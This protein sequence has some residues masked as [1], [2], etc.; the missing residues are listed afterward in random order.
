M[1]LQKLRMAFAQIRRQTEGALEEL[2][3]LELL[4]DPRNAMWRCDG[5]G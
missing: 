4:L 3:A 2:D 1:K 5:C